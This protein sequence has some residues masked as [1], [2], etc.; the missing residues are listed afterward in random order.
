MTSYSPVPTARSMVVVPAAITLVVTTIRLALEF[1]GAPSWLAN[2]APGGPGALLGIAWLPLL[3]GPW[4]ATRIR[5]ATA[6]NRAVWKPLAK[7]MLLYGLLARLPV[8]L[9]TIPAVLGHWG[10]HYDAFPP[11]MA[12]A[13]PLAKIGAGFL[14][15]IGFWACI[16]TVLTGTLAGMLFVALRNR[17]R[18]AVAQFPGS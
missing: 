13:S 12:D 7:T 6:T 8:A 9:L 3:F 14:A 1:Y 11:G 15:Q 2:S 18:V 4:F 5:E 10:T 17:Q 16:W